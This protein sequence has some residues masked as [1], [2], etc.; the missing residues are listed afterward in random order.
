MNSRI[1]KVAPVANLNTPQS[2]GTGN[3]KEK[4]VFSTLNLLET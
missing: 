2:I 3:I 1:E 4:K